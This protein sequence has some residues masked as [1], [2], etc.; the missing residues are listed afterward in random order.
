[1]GREKIEVLLF[2]NQGYFLQEF[3]SISECARA[4]KSH[5]PQV[6]RVISGEDLSANG[7]QIRKKHAKINPKRIGDLSKE[8]ADTVIVGKYW[9]DKLIC[10]Y[11]SINEA[12]LI[13]GIGSGNISE[14]ITKGYKCKGFR[15]K[16]IV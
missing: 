8:R 1:M 16:S 6:N 4:I 11:P 2:D 14:S 7:F 13:T 10:V 9:N 12:S 15:F 5:Q 3:S